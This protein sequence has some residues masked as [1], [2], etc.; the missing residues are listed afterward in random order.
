[1]EGNPGKVPERV[2]LHSQSPP[3]GAEQ[4]QQRKG[5]DRNDKLVSSPGAHAPKGS[6]ISVHREPIDTSFARMTPPTGSPAFL[7]WASS[8]PP[9][10]DDG[11]L[12]PRLRNNREAGQ[13]ASTLAAQSNTLPQ[14]QLQSSTSFH[15]ELD[16]GCSLTRA[17][18]WEQEQS[19]CS[20]ARNEN[21]KSKPRITIFR[22]HSRS[23]S[24]PLSHRSCQAWAGWA[25]HSLLG[26][27]VHFFSSF[28]RS[29]SVSGYQCPTK[30]H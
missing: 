25:G 2:R 9:L 18:V 20:R 12:C 11:V 24:Q 4:S 3:K 15:E 7:N 21:Q 16:A 1:M 14:P 22:W 13:R 27:I 23:Q 8:Q 30:D 19:L 10:A 28:A 6:S 26:F 29:Y 17:E 5:K